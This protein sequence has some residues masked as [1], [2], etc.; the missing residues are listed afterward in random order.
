[1]RDAYGYEL[2][3]V[4]HRLDPSRPTPWDKVVLLHDLVQ[5]NDV[6]VW[7]DV[8]AIVLPDAPD[9]ADAMVPGRFLH[10]VEHHT[11]AGPGSQ[12][13]SDGDLR[14]RARDASSGNACG[15]SGA[16]STIVWWENSAVIRVLG[17]RTVR[18]RCSRSCRRAGARPRA[19]RRCVEQHSDR[20]GT[21]AVHRAFP[22]RGSRVPEAPARRSWR[23][24]RERI[25][26]RARSRSSPAAAPESGAASSSDSR[27]EGAA[28]VF[29][30]IDADR[31]RAV[32]ARS[33]TV[34]SAS[35]AT[36]A[37]DGVAEALVT[38]AR[39]NFG[40]VD[41]LGQ[42]RRSLRRRAQGVP[43]ADRRGVG[44]PLP[45]QPRARAHVLA[46]GAPGVA[47]A[48]RRRQHRQRVDDRG[49]PCD[50]DSCGV[51]GVQVPRSPGLTRSLAV[52]Y[53]RDTV[54]A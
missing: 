7:I 5:T 25:A 15:T 41:M 19:P 54:C 14:R 32:Q 43:R 37:N 52:E 34:S 17:Y 9:I 8:D 1:M 51:L 40:R 13:G 11:F 46:R 29:A 22:G 20:P 39:D 47:R 2:V 24:C 18:R 49:L 28:V 6:V 12:L 35:C 33:A 36:C 50:P 53:A 27:H 45:R 30:E 21:A 26:R 16:A 38:A 44:R 42:Q 4:R 3:V 10:L 31:A 48:G 23:R